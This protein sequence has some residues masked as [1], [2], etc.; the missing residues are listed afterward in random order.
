MTWFKLSWITGKIGKNFIVL[1]KFI[2]VNRKHEVHLHF[3][4]IDIHRNWKL[5]SYICALR[6]PLLV[7]PSWTWIAYCKFQRT[8]SIEGRLLGSLH[9]QLMVIS[10]A[11]FSD[12]YAKLPWIEGSMA[13]R[14]L[15]CPS[16]KP[17]SSCTLKT[18]RIPM[19]KLPPETV[20]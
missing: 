3:I 17:F 10:T 15:D 2:Q 7:H 20:W 9:R 14:S 19:N 13:T 4:R 18:K 12:W 11:V 1:S 5:R 16:V 6:L 8:L